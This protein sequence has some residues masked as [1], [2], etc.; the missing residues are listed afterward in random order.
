MPGWT[1]PRCSGFWWLNVS[2]RILTVHDDSLR[3]QTAP[4]YSYDNVHWWRWFSR[5]GRGQFVATR[6]SDVALLQT[7]IWHVLCILGS[8]QLFFVSKGRLFLLNRVPHRAAAALWSPSTSRTG[9]PTHDRIQA[10]GDSL[11]FILIFFYF[12]HSP[13]IKQQT[14]KLTK[15]K[16]P[17]RV[18]AQHCPH[19]TGAKWESA[20]GSDLCSSSALKATCERLSSLSEQDSSVSWPQSITV[21]CLRLVYNLIYCSH[22]TRWTYGCAGARVPRR[23]SVALRLMEFGRWSHFM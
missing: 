14:N 6:A 10:G 22:D 5:G 11:F 16:K 2:H 7:F 21:N 3:R 8:P 15:K 12:I 18:S 13:G 4:L 1:G 20:T 19:V 23:S 17:N 9:L